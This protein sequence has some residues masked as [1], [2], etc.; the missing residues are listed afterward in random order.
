[1]PNIL[2]IP[3]PKKKFEAYL[4]SMQVGW[5]DQLS[6]SQK[7]QLFKLAVVD[8]YAGKLS[9]DDLDGIASCLWDSLTHEEKR[10]D[11]V[12]NIMLSASDLGYLT[13]AIKGDGTHYE[14]LKA[15]L[16]KIRNFYESFCL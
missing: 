5:V 9:A 13:R 1:M 15:T 12:G 14:A 10:G 3:F 6:K 11:W 4:S 8:F 7:D 16:I 2:F